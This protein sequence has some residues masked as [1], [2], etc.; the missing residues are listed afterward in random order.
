MKKKVIRHRRRESLRIRKKRWS[1]RL[2]IFSGL[3]LT[4]FFFLNLGLS[5]TIEVMPYANE[6]VLALIT[7]LGVSFVVESYLRLKRGSIY[8]IFYSSYIAFTLVI[9]SVIY[10]I[11]YLSGIEIGIFRTLIVV[12][13]I[14]VFLYSLLTLKHSNKIGFIIAAYVFTVLITIIVFAYIYWTLSIFNL[15]HLQFTEC[16]TLKPELKSENWFYF[17]AGT[18]YALGY[19]D[20]CPVLPTARFFSQF[21]VAMGALINTIL[22]GFIFWKLRE[23]SYK[24]EKRNKSA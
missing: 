3:A 18:F 11:S 12:T 1:L 22:L 8:E 14:I 21:E 5:R 15:G 17:S 10:W 13:H 16:N 24:E 20:I 9:L 19:G 7:I 4:L 23:I 6:V 2:L